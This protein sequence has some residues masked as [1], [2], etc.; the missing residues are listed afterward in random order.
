MPRTRNDTQGGFMVISSPSGKH[1]AEAAFD[2]GL[3][4]RVLKRGPLRDLYA[5]NLA[6]A[7]SHA[8]FVRW[9]CPLAKHGLAPCWQSSCCNGV[10]DASA[11]SERA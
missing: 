2:H 6:L 1:R 9:K 3:H 11:P 4:A 8:H 10:A 7:V 5:P